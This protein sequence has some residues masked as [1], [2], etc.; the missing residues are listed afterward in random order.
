[1]KAI[2]VLGG[3]G[4]IGSHAAKEVHKTGHLPIV[5]DDLSS[6]H[7]WAVKYGPLVRA[8]IG[9]QETLRRV[10][11]KYEIKDVMHFAAKAYVGE[12]MVNPGKYFRENV[13]KTIS[14]L[15][16][17]VSTGVER[18]IFSS[19][20]ATYG[21]PQSLPIS[22]SHPQHPV[23]PYG[24]TKLFV[25]KMLGW[26]GQAH[27]LR[28]VALR[29]FNAAGADPEGDLGEMHD[30][31]THLIPCAIEAALG[32]R[33][34]LDILGT[35]YATPDG[36]AI[37]DY[38]HVSDLARAHVLALDYLAAGG[39]STAMNLGTGKG[40]SVME[41]ADAVSKACERQVPV[42]LQPRREGDPAHLVAD[43][44]RARKLL[45]WTPN[46]DTLDGIVETAA[47]WYAGA[48]A[49]QRA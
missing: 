21:N 14:L 20:C 18:M 31:E 3:A 32:Q 19:T 29:Y 38:T 40:H 5:L 23:N 33:E 45:G 30:P 16:V 43:A 42:R 25:E 8:D 34:H 1:M 47:A 36:T 27:G 22:E 10:I 15:D 7:Q 48:A 37:R 17:L 12:S 26:Y 28:S 41:V 11:R 2:L 49:A 13:A 44:S 24:E 9:D 4:Y 35:D 39:N 46:I 6:G